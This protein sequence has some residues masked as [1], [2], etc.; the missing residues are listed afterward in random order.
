MALVKYYHAE[1]ALNVLTFDDGHVHIIQQLNPIR[2][3]RLPAV[4]DLL[5]ILDESRV[6]DGDMRCFQ[7]SSTFFF[8]SESLPQDLF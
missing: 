4:L 2:W 8:V 6:S 3:W 1:K 7:R 5:C